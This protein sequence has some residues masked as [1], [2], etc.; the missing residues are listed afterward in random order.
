MGEDRTPTLERFGEEVRA[1]LTASPK[2]LPCAWFYDEVGSLLFEEICDQPEYYPTRAEEEILRSRAGEIAEVVSSLEGEFSLV[3]LGSGSSVKTRH[4]IEAF[5]ARGDGLRYVPVDISRSML[6][7]SARRLVA[8][9]PS[10]RVAGVAAE[11]GAGLKMV[12]ERFQGRELVLWLGSNVGNLER[13]EAVGFLGDLRRGLGE[14]DRFLM[15]V[16]LRKDPEVLE[17]AYDDAA[18]VSARFNLNLL[19]RI[20]RELGGHFDLATFAH[21]AP[22]IEEEGRIEMHLE[23]LVDQTV[24]IDALGI[25]VSFQA[26]ETIHTENSTKYSLEE[27]DGL[28]AA[29][30]FEVQRRWLDSGERFALQLL[31]PR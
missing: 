4:L 21:R 8:D 3:E 12:R 27:I 31:R 19:A 25:E 15:G 18:G 24:A 28:A 10:L 2:T 11:Y 5:L 30:G 1:G 16:D 9:Y 22:W 7:E 29:S 14:D 26:G 23:S 20:N 17:A 6:E 13:R